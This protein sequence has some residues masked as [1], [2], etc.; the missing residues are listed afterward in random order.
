M[1]LKSQCTS[2][3]TVELEKP[4]VKLHFPARS[5]AALQ[6]PRVPATPQEQ[7][8]SRTASPRAR[9]PALRRQGGAPS[10]CSAANTAPRQHGAADML[11]SRCATT[12][13][14]CR[15]ERRRCNAPF[16]GCHRRAQRELWPPSPNRRCSHA[17]R[18]RCSPRPSRIGRR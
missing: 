18:G 4:L 5:L 7:R 13:T 9:N 6:A 8:G 11:W 16:G 17:A 3:V 10:A 15:R 2:R 12:Q 1:Q 14:C